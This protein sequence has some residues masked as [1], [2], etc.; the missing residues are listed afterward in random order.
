MSAQTDVGSRLITLIL[1]PFPS[2]LQRGNRGSDAGLWR[3]GTGRGEEGEQREEARR[4]PQWDLSKLGWGSLGD[5]GPERRRRAHGLVLKM[6]RSHWETG[7]LEGVQQDLERRRGSPG[8]KLGKA[9][10]LASLFPWGQTWKEMLRNFAEERWD[11]KVL[12]FLWGR[13]KAIVLSFSALDSTL[14]V[15]RV[16]SWVN[17]YADPFPFLL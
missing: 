8:L 15:C 10:S 12:K 7:S 14:W 4:K 2:I 11:C 6:S 5:N 9:N 16:E 17:A 3:M 1:T 13:R